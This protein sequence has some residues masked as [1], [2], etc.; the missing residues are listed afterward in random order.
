VAIGVRLSQVFALPSWVE[1]GVGCSLR[2]VQRL[3]G[4]ARRKQNIRVV[5]VYAG[6]EPDAVVKKMELAPKA[7]WIGD[8]SL[9]GEIGEHRE[10]SAS[11]LPMCWSVLPVLVAACS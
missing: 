5:A 3:Y 7:R 11:C 2:T 4:G 6:G 9:L 10:R 1:R 8:T